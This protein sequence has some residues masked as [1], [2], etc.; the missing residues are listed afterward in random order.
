VANKG[1]YCS[2]GIVGGR[3]NSRKFH[4]KVRPKLPGT[5]RTI[6]KHN[7]Y[8][9]PYPALLL[10][11]LELDLGQQLIDLPTRAALFERT[12]TFLELTANKQ[13]FSFHNFCLKAV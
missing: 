8:L 3:E 10:R 4:Q 7:I 12:L 11:C 13:Y 1:E 5:I 9:P 6:Q 2:P